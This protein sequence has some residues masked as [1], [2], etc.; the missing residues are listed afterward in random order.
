[1]TRITVFTPTY[2]RAYIIEKLYKSLQ[3]QTYRNFEWLVIDDGSTDNTNELIN[4]FIKES[5]SFGITYIKKINGGQHSA[6][7]TGIPLAKGELFMIVDSDDYLD[8]FALEC[9]DKWEK[10]I[11][12]KKDL[13]AGISGLRRYGNGINIGG[14]FSEDYID[15]SNLDRNKFNLFGDKAEAYYTKVLREFSP[16]PE[17]ENEN[18][19]EKA[20]LWNRIAAAGYQVR[21]F[22]KAIYI[23]EYLNDGMTKNI[24]NNY[25][26]N[27]QGYTLYVKEFITYN[28]PLKDK[29]R[30]IRYYANI[31]KL[32]NISYSQMAINLQI[33]QLYLISSD[34]LGEIK[35]FY[36]KLFLKKYYKKR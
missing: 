30:M 1:M 10:T 32:K 28:I 12:N 23:G 20:V 7:N 9:I 36:N 29:M 4:K 27:Y 21:W 5:N 24:E 18:D 15:S 11:S 22:N 17:Y 14:V 16:L 31:S 8:N 2:N 34:L 19:V 33:N 26:R 35:Q 25:I 3:N 6:L 13:F